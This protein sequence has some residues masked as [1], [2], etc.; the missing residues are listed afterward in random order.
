[1]GYFKFSREHT[2]LH[3]AEGGNT[4]SDECVAIVVKS[5]GLNCLINGSVR[6]FFWPRGSVKKIN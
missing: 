6:Y 4:V 1:V 3:I 5:F 2:E